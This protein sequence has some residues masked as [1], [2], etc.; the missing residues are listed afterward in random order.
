MNQLKS[1]P[2]TDN[3]VQIDWP[4]YLRMLEDPLYRSAKSYYYLGSMRIEMQPVGFDHGTNHSLISMA[5]SLYGILHGLP[6]TISDACSYRKAG[7]REC[8]PD[9]SVYLGANVA[10]IPSNTNIVNLDRYPAPNLV[11]EISKTTLFDDLGAKRSLYE[12]IGIQEYWVVDVEKAQI[13]AYAMQ[14][15]GSQ[16]I[17]ISLVLPSLTL[18]VLEQALVQGRTLDQSAIGAW[19]MEQFRST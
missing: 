3:W 17:S 15:R 5:V 9:L 14:D 13:F 18:A 1:L 8:Q 4:D 12:A 2:L 16:Q 19:L 6:L 11:I 10:A 7:Q